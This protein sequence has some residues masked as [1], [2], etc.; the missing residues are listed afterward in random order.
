MNLDNIQN[1]NTLYG[2]CVFCNNIKE[3]INYSVKIIPI[4]ITDIKYKYKEN[5]HYIKFYI[6]DVKYSNKIFEKELKNLFED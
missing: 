6:N 3:P 1:G 5:N 2:A 4:K